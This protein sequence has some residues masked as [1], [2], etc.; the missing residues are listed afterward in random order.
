MHITS[1]GSLRHTR[2]WASWILSTLS[3]YFF[4]THYRLHSAQVSQVQSRVLRP[5]QKSFQVRGPVIWENININENLTLYELT[6]WKKQRVGYGF[7]CYCC[8]C[9]HKGRS[10]GCVNQPV[11]LTSASA[12]AISSTSPAVS[13]AAATMRNECRRRARSLAPSFIATL[14][15]LITD[16]KVREFFILINQW[17]LILCSQTYSIIPYRL[18]R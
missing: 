2:S 3:H 4:H 16:V 5:C 13:I 10:V 6:S 17:I 12:P 9:I 18:Y 14:V 8:G 1:T 7:C 15:L 11:R